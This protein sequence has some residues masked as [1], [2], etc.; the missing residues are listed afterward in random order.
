MA[1]TNFEE[2]QL[3]NGTITPPNG[4]DIN[5]LLLQAGVGT[6][7]NFRQT[8][9]TAAVATTSGVPDNPDAYNYVDKMQRVGRI[10]YT[11]TSQQVQHLV[12]VFVSLIGEDYNIGQVQNANA[13]AW[14]AVMGALMLRTLELLAGVT[15]AEKQAYTNA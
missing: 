5:T 11:A 2:I 6:I 12:R 9:K 7:T 15:I 13:A 14:E 8:Y 4:V 1:L 3:I 10:I